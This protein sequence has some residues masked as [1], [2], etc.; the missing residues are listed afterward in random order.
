MSFWL[1]TRVDP[2]NHVLDRVHIDATWWIRLNR[3]FAVAMR[4]YLQLLWPLGI[5]VAICHYCQLNRLYYI[6]NQPLSLTSAI[7]IQVKRKMN[8]NMLLQDNIFI[9][10]LESDKSSAYLGCDEPN[11]AR[12]VGWRQVAKQ[13]AG[14]GSG[15]WVWRINRSTE[16]HVVGVDDEDQTMI[17]YQRRCQRHLRHPTVKHCN[18]ARQ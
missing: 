5:V 16:E 15:G 2:T 6:N 11:G 7:H 14:D 17:A 13:H 4:P 1:W 12:C 10:L 3:P 9:K 8:T 18:R